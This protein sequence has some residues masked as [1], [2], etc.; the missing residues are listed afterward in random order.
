VGKTDSTFGLPSNFKWPQQ[1]ANIEGMGHQV[2]VE[3]VMDSLK[4]GRYSKTHKQ[5]DSIRHIRT[6]YANFGRVVDDLFHRHMAL[7][8]EMGS[9]H[10][11]STSPT[12]S[13]W[14]ERFA[15]GCKRRMGQDWRPDLPISAGLLKQIMWQAER[16]I[17]NE[18]ATVPIIT[19]TTA[20][21]FYFICCYVLSLRGDEG[22]LI[23]ARPLREKPHANWIKSLAGELHIRDSLLVIPLLGKVK[24]ELHAREHLLPCVSK[25]SSGIDVGLWM[26]WLNTIHELNQHLEGPAIADKDRK[27]LTSAKLDEILH[28]LLIEVWKVSPHLFPQKIRSIEDIKKWYSIFRSFRRASDSRAISEAISQ[29][30]IDIINRWQKLERAAGRKISHEHMRHYYADMHM[31]LPV[32]VRYTLGM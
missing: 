32:F 23:N 21:M 18:N 31:L 17:R 1:L 12:A 16:R 30:D 20:A 9:V 13:L 5:W 8:S 7:V 4:P 24:G 26:D 28:D 3:M 29:D 14:L 15:Q 11:P 22:R 25:T 10:R 19:V 6:S 2:A 27:P